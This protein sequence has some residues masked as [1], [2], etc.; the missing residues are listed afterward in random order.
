MNADA[1]FYQQ[2]NELFT[3]HQ[4]DGSFVGLSCF[5]DGDKV[6]TVGIAGIGPRKLNHQ[7]ILFIIRKINFKKSFCIVTYDGAYTSRVNQAYTRS[8]ADLCPDAVIV[9]QLVGKLLWD[10]CHSITLR[11]MNKHLE[12]R[13]RPVPALEPVLPLPFPDPVPFPERR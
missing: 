6:A 3:V 11:S 12:S 4:G 13:S 8:F 2:L 10:R 9:Q 7:K 1:V 5:L